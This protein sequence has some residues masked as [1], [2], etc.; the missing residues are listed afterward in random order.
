MYTIRFTDN[1]IV[2]FL[3]DRI[4]RNKD[5]PAVEFFNG[6]KFWHQHSLKHRIYGP[7]RMFAG[8]EKDYWITGQ[9]VTYKTW[10]KYVH[11]RV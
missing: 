3:N 8:G 9:L 1:S 6:S 11:N 7:A 4:H 5:L 10:K 2:W